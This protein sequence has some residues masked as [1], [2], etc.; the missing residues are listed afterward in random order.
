MAGGAWGTD[1]VIPH[2]VADG[3]SFSWT[4]LISIP[5]GVNVENARLVGLV[6]LYD[7]D[8]HQRHILN[9][10]E[11]PAISTGEIF[12]DGFESGNTAAWSDAF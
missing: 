1:D 11:K 5:E 7:A 6:S 12:A 4:Y 10:T 3:D 8:S 9:A 2:T